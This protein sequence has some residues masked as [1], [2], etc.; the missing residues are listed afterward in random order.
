[1]SL[2]DPLDCSLRRSSVHGIFQAN[3]TAVGCHFL[4]QGIFQTQ[5]SNLSLLSP[6]LQ[7]DFLPDK[8]SEKPNFGSF[9]VPFDVNLGYL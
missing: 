2:F 7:A 9:L 1:M 4:L 5:G 6:A 8:P 3:N